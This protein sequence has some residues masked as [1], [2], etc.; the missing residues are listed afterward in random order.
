[1][2]TDLQTQH[3]TIPV[4]GPVPEMKAYVATPGGQP[5][6]ALI[7]IHEAFGLDSHIEDMTRRFAGEGYV[8][9]APDLFSADEVGRTISPDEIKEIFR[10]RSSL[11]AD[12][13]RDPDA[14]N[15]AIDK[16][17]P[18]KAERLRAVVQ[19]QQNR[20]NSRFV[21]LLEETVAWCRNRSDTTEKVGAVGFCMGGG[22]VSALAFAGADI[23]AGA[24]FYGQN[25]PLDQAGQV[26]CPL[27]F[28]YGRNDPFIMPGVPKLLTTL[29]DAKLTY[30]LHIYE[31]AGHAFMNDARP[32]MYNGAAA[33]DAWPLTLA[34]FDRHL[35]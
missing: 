29:E 33:K 1:M 8:A 2:S 3:T 13:R 11:P 32:E 27:L 24:P 31:E 22:L 10:L 35:S 15:R 6:P 5:R 28:I 18:D 25:P 12:Q 30:G 7:V 19:W 9:V 34:F 21:T 4:Q 23:Q 26:R 17:S 16:L 14:L 20:D